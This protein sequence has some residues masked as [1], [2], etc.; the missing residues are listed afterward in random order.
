MPAH[1]TR[2]LQH[3]DSNRGDSPSAEHDSDGAC[4]GDEGGGLRVGGVGKLDGRADGVDV[5]K[6]GEVGEVGAV[7]RLVGP[8]DGAHEM[9]PTSHASSSVTQRGKRVL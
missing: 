7:G 2:P 5:A 6:V 3:G 1:V 4:A 8:Y 9:T